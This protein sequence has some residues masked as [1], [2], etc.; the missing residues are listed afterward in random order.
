[1]RTDLMIEAAAGAA[2]AVA[3]AVAVERLEPGRKT[4]KAVRENAD[5]DSPLNDHR[6]IVANIA[7]FLVARMVFRG[8][9]SGARAAMKAAR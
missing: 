4:R 6:G 8:V 5:A 2:A 1:M 7:C 9:F 3:T